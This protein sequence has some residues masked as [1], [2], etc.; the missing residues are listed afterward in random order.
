MAL[1]G[2][3]VEDE[4]FYTLAQEGAEVEVVVKD[5]KVI[6]CGKEFKFELSL[7]EEKLIAA[8]GVT[9]MYQKYGSKLFRAAV[10][11]EGGLSGGGCGSEASKGDGCGTDSRELA[12]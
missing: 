1:L 3:T 10:A 9:E 2:I 5:R 7:M 8:G 6:C 12:W 11:P 4:E